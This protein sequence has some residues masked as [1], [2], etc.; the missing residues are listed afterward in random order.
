MLMVKT[1]VREYR[2]HTRN[3]LEGLRLGF[4]E[5]YIDPYN[6]VGETV[7]D[8]KDNVTEYC[9]NLKQY[10]APYTSLVTS[11]M[12]GKSRL[13]KEI[14]HSIPSV[15][16]C[17]RERE[18]SGYPTCTPTLPEFINQG[19][20]DQ[21]VIDESDIRF[22][23]PTL[24]FCLSLLALIRNL[25]ILVDQVL[26]GREVSNTDSYLWMWQ[27]FAE[28]VLSEDVDRR[29]NFWDKVAGEAK[30][31][32]KKLACTREGTPSIAAYEYLRVYFGRE[33]FDAYAS[34]KRAF[35]IIDDEDFNL[36][37]ICDEARILW[38]ISAIDGKI[39]PTD[40]DL[41]LKMEIHRPK[42]ANY[43]PFSNFWAFRRALC[44]LSLVG[45][46]KALPATVLLKQKD[47]VSKV[48]RADV[49]RIFA[50]FTDTSSRLTNFQP[51]ECEDQSLRVLS[52]PALGNKQFDSIF[53]FRSMTC[54]R[55]I[56]MTNA[57][58]TSIWLPTHLD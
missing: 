19:V 2:L 51:T 33:V 4:Q 56:R 52:L 55:C 28:P 31:E 7:K 32:M 46:S 26:L 17:L 53:T 1:P 20:I 57:H 40:F 10:V 41:D 37:L 14:A 18:F 30:L 29:H 9:N 36:L 15:Y 38:D 23:I 39:I 22:M 50:L 35:G 58:P 24:K 3:D 16:M 13:M 48:M 11:S 44:Y 42:E 47:A 25:F 21:G 43:P 54:I 8:I 27:L 49:S 5:E 45:Q 6:L 34:L 12:M